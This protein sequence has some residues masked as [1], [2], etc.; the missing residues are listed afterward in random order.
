MPLYFDLHLDQFM[1]E[2]VV[3]CSMIGGYQSQSAACAPYFTPVLEIH[4]CHLVVSPVQTASPWGSQSSYQPSL[5]KTLFIYH[6]FRISCTICTMLHE[7]PQTSAT[8]FIFKKLNTRRTS[9]LSVFITLAILQ[10]HVLASDFS[11]TRL[12]LIEH[13]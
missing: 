5:H 7:L 12:E 11:L 3:S 8:S 4:W 13:F 1:C 9:S 2:N 6:L 10:F